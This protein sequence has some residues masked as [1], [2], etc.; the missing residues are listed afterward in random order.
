MTKMLFSLFITLVVAAVLY[1]SYPVVTLV[2]LAN[3]I[4]SGDDLSVDAFVDWPKVREGL[5]SQLMADVTKD[6]FATAR[7]GDS[8]SKAGAMIG[9]ALGSSLAD[10]M[11]DGLFNSANLIRAFKARPDKD[12]TAIDWFCGLRPVSPTRVNFEICHPSRGSAPPVR[13][14]MTLEGMEWQIVRLV[15]PRRALDAAKSAVDGIDQLA[16][17]SPANPQ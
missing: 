9:L 11:F 8:A 5:K 1:A 3:A 17:V 16:P 12:K 4:D 2:R 6:T 13:A 10:R 14:V 15:I 7:G